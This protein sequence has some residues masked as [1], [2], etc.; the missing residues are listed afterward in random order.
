MGLKL[1]K[2]VVPKIDFKRYAFTNHFGEFSIVYV[3]LE[4]IFIY[5]SY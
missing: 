4:R 5:S 2:Y 1:L 3:I